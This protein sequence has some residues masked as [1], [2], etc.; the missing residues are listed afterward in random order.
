MSSSSV[1]L[2]GLGHSIYT[3]IARLALEEKGVSY[4]LEEA[5]PFGPDGVPAEHLKRHPFGRIPVLVHADFLL[6]ETSAICRYIDEVFPGPQLQP[7]SGAHR[8]RMTQVISL[9]D[10]YAYRPMVWDVFVQHRRLIV[11]GTKPDEAAFDSALR[12][13]ETALR[14][15]VEIKESSR[16]LV[17]SQLTLADLH[18][19][20]ML[21]Y[22]A[23]VPEGRALIARYPTLA[24]WLADMAQRQSVAATSSSY[25]HSPQKAD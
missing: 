18:A 2:L 10:S 17:G 4:E 20:P 5:D 24:E 11:K 8:A 22:F 6:Y 16:Y 15:I 9:L 25:E 14:A 21:R 19:F 3:R 23:L 13:A 12:Q 7:A 1:R